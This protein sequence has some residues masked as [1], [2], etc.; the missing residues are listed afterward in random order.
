MLNA[1]E[2]WI[3]I[4]VLVLNC[5][6]FGANCVERFV[7]YQSWPKL[8][9][10][11][12]GPYHRSQQPWIFGF[13]VAP[14]AVALVLQISLLLSRPQKIATWILWT[15]IGSSAAGFVSTVALQIPIHRSLDE[16]YSERLVA[17]LLR[18]DWIRKLADLIRLAGTIAL[19]HFVLS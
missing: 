16:A 7:N 2:T 14:L 11:D 9:S 19:L 4:S 5:Y 12:F 15:L 6:S 18:T 10:A 17:R 8:A 13:V 3:V 1:T